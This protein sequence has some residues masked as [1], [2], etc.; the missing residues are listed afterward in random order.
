MNWL[1]NFVPPKLR[2]L[3][4]V[5][6][7]VPDN[8]WHKCSSCSQ[9]VFHRDLAKT[10]H[11]CPHCGHH[12]RLDARTRLDLLF[13]TDPYH[14]LDLPKARVDPLKFKDRRKYTDRLKEAQNK[15]GEQDALIVAEGTMAGNPVVTAIFNFDFMAGSMGVAVGDGLI[16]ASKRAVKNKAAF[17]V[18][19]ASGGARMQEGIYSLMQMARTTIAVQQV[20]EAGLPYI[21]LLTDPTTGGVTASFAMLGDIALAEPGCLIGFAGQRVI[22]QTIRETLPEGFQRAEYLLE[23]GMIDMVVTRT[24]LRK[25][26]V[27]ILSLI[28][29]PVK[30]GGDGDVEDETVL[31][32][33]PSADTEISDR[34]ADQA[35]DKQ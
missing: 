14:L 22:E 35:D 13:D 20:Q 34:Q 30:N 17:I 29:Q 25:T 15:T 9:M 19:P 8:L 6:K 11:V 28:M 2:Q 18:I 21:V 16:E 26:L 7:D 24:E 1:K 23:H 12:M 32:A 27:K 31:I 10:L 33:A 4:G 3:V 5:E